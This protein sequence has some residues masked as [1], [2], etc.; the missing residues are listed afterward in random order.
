ME[1]QTVSK[2]ET[3]RKMKTGSGVIGAV[4]MVSV[5]IYIVAA[6][7]MFITMKEIHGGPESRQAFIKNIF[8]Y[9]MDSCVMFLASAVFFRIARN[10]CPFIPSNI[11]IVRVIGAILILNGVI[12]AAIPAVMLET[13]KLLVSMINP[14]GIASGLLVIFISYIMHY[15]SLLQVESDET[16]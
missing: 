15:A 2:I 1:Q 5:V 11:L 10:G 8:S 7:M 4:C 6:I 16:L 9:G 14:S 3:I 13:P 12:S